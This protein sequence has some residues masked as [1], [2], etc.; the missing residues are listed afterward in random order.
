[1]C[2]SF[3]LLAYIGEAL[4]CRHTLPLCISPLTAI[5]HGCLMLK[6]EDQL[7]CRCWSMWCPASLA[8]SEG[9]TLPANMSMQSHAPCM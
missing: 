6:L 7:R 3:Q 2:P 8:A 1:M 4:I 5:Y 9:S